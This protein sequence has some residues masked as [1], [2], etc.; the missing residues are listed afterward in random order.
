MRAV[1]GWLLSLALL[2]LAAPA[3]THGGHVHDAEAPSWTWNPWVTGPLLLSALLFARGWKR[4]HAR[5][6]VAQRACGGG[7]GASRVAG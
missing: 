5:R 3:S 4:L 7:R 6:D 1:S 2:A